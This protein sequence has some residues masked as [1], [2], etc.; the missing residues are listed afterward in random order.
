MPMKPEQKLS[1]RVRSGFSRLSCQ[2]TQIVEA[3]VPGPADLIIEWP[4]R[5]FW[6]ELKSPTA[7]FR[8]AQRDFLKAHWLLNHNAF[9]LKQLS[10][11]AYALW[12]G[13]DALV[14]GHQVWSNGT[15]N[16]ESIKQSMEMEHA[17]A[18]GS[19]VRIHRKFR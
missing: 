14:P 9:L 8:Q 3:G 19:I 18:N 15:L 4:G 10:D 5:W 16:I 13:I 6:L 1:E 11:T 7:P 12:R 17:K 2:V